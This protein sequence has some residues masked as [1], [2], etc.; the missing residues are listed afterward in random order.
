MNRQFTD[1]AIA[2]ENLLP[3]ILF[4]FFCR[5]VKSIHSNESLFSI[6]SIKT[7]TTGILPKSPLNRF[8]GGLVH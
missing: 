5:A 2:Y 3:T 8:G 1:R 6:I 4:E 7:N